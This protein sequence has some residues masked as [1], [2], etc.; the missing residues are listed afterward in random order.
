M[1]VLFHGE[2]RGFIV[3]PGADVEK[4]NNPKA[5]AGVEVSRDFFLHVDLASSRSV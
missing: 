2:K 4:A 5:H 1:A 3:T